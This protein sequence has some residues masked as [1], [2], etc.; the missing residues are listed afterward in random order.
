LPLDV[1][2]CSLGIREFGKH[3][4][5][6]LAREFGTLE[7]VLKVTREELSNIHSI[8]DIIAGEVVEGLKAKRPLID[9]LLKYVTVQNADVRKNPTGPLSGKSFLFTG[10]MIAMVRGDAEKEVESKGGSIASGVTKTLDYLVVGDG[11]GAGSK[12][13]K[14]KKLI[15]AGAKLKIISEEEFLKFLR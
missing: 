3:V 8:G 2:L 13:D 6:I 5:Q 10:S 15:E 1:F 7:R 12:L 4:S 14:A 11:G 9:K